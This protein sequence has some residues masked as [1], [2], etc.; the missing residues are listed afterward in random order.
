VLYDL[1]DG[2]RV[3]AIAVAPFLPTTAPQILEALGQP[4]D[5]AWDEVQPGRTREVDGIE[6]AQPLF[7]RIEQPAAA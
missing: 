3:V 2:L 5:L 6:A 4:G 7:P 1:A